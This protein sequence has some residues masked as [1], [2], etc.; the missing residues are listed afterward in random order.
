MWNWPILDK[1]CT[2]EILILMILAQNDAQNR[3]L[4]SINRSPG[5]SAALGAPNWLHK[6]MRNLH[7]EAVRRWRLGPVV[8]RPGLVANRLQSWARGWHVGPHAL[9]KW[10]GIFSLLVS[11]SGGPVDLCE[12]TCRTLIGRNFVP[13]IMPCHLALNLAWIHLQTISNQYR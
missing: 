3:S 8:G 5:S 13:W 2:N 4:S 6:P 10:V 1:T 7:V 12:A 11:C 9:G